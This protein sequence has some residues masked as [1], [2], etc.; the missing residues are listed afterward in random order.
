MCIYLL[1]YAYSVFIPFVD[2]PG[3]Q[4]KS[5]IRIKNISK[6]PVAFK[7]HY[8]SSLNFLVFVVLIVDILFFA[9]VKCA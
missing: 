8:Y 2:E 7:V 3:K 5:A 4:V 6:N 1:D 9:D